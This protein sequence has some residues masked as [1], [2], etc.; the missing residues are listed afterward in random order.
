MDPN[1]LHPDMAQGS[2][3]GQG[4]ARGLQALAGAPRLAALCLDGCRL[5]R[6][7]MRALGS[8]L[9]GLTEL[10]ISRRCGRIHL[11]VS[12]ASSA[13]TTLPGRPCNYTHELMC[14]CTSMHVQLQLESTAASQ[15]GSGAR[16]IPGSGRDRDI[17]RCLKAL[18]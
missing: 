5:T 3:Q 7:A 9:A 2:S 14:L 17:G 15:G 12:E 13:A 8:S 11:Q 18:H 1:R 6:G 10:D 4:L 16:L